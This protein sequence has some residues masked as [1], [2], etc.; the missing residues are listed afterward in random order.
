MVEMS[1]Q[2]RSILDFERI[3][4]N[5]KYYDKEA[6]CDWVCCHPDKGLPFVD[7]ENETC[8]DWFTKYDYKPTYLVSDDGRIMEVEDD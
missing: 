1:E 8:A 4:K 7:D 5:C 6:G 2:M 3:C